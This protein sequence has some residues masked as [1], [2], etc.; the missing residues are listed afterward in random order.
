MAGR[1]LRNKSNLRKYWDVYVRP[2]PEVKRVLDAQEYACK[3]LV[4][5]IQERTQKLKDDP[6]YKLPEDVISW[7]IVESQ[8]M[9][10]PPTPREQAL[11]HLSP[12]LA[13]IHTETVTLINAMF[14]LAGH[15]QYINALREE[16]DPVFAKQ[17]ADGFSTAN[18]TKL[19]SLLKESQ[20]MHPTGYCKLYAIHFPTQL[21]R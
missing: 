19:D 8:E 11:Q 2:I 17:K 16:I 14:D 9:E 18:F 5:I 13:G 15:P 21:G 4:P 3:T 12:T 10:H 20:R 7:V 1:A 6:K